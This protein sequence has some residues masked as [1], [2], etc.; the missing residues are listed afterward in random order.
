MSKHLKL[1]CKSAAILCLSVAVVFFVVWLVLWW[2]N[3]AM[4]SQ[5]LLRRYW[6]IALCGIVAAFLGWAFSQGAE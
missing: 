6:E 2:Q 4:T 5:Q 1:L 3:P